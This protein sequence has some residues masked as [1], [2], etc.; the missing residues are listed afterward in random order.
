M[1]SERNNKKHCKQTKPRTACETISIRVTPEEK[2]RLYRISGACRLT[3]TETFKHLLSQVELKAIPDSEF[4]RLRDELSGIR[5]DIMAANIGCDNAEHE[6]SLLRD[7][8]TDFKQTCV[9]FYG[10]GIFAPGYAQAKADYWKEID[11]RPPVEDSMLEG[12]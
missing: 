1:Y 12:D 10:E 9:K 11:S 5:E 2:E 7:A 8:M 3:L 6:L 4:W